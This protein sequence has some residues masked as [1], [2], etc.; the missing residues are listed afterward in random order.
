EVRNNF[1]WRVEG[2]RIYGPGT[3]DIKGG[4]LVIYMMMAALKTFLPDLYDDITWVI[5]LDASE[6]TDGADFGELCEQHLAGNTLACLIFEGGS[7]QNNQFK[8]VVARKGMAMYHTT[9][10]GKASHAGSAH[11]HGANAI[12]QMADFIQN[13]AALTDYEKEI[14]YNVGTVNGGV[15]T[16]RVPHL[17]TAKIEMRAFDQGIYEEGVVN[18]LALAEEIT[19]RSPHDGYACQIDIKITRR[20]KPWQRNQQTDDLFAIWHAAAEELGYSVIEEER[21]GLSDGNY[22]WDVIPSIDG[23]GPSGGNAHCSERSEDGAKDQEFVSTD[24]FIPKTMLNIAGI[25]KLVGY[26]A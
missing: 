12:V 23:L 24:S 15:V 20:T 8:L 6:E 7:F 13:V 14:T 11:E 17:A 16:N 1:H 9:I 19:V 22:F 10:T 4:T 3:V 18:M 21:G 26:Q 5:L 25:L 2:D